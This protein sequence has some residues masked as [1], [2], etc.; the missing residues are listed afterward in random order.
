M[1]GFKLFFF[2]F[3]FELIPKALENIS[4]SYFC[5]LHIIELLKGTVETL[6]TD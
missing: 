2:S 1:S 3:F 5:N 4:Y 6:L